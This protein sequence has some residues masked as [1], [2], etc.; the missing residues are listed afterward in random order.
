M[1]TENTKIEIRDA[2]SGDWV[3]AHK[4]ILFSPFISDS[5]YRVYCGLASFAGNKDQRSWPSLITLAS[6]LHM[7]KS[8]VIRAIKLLSTC[9]LVSIEKRSGISNTYTL[10]DC[11]EIELPKAP[12]RAQSTHHQLIDFFHKASIR[13]RNV[14][15][16][17]NG[18]ETAHLK[19]V[20]KEGTLSVE[21]I[22][23]LMVYFLASPRFKKFAPT[24]STFFSAGIFVGLKNAM[25]NDSTFWKDIDRFSSMMFD[26]PKQRAHIPM[27]RMDQLTKMLAEKMSIKKEYEHR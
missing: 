4:N 17:W 19:R 15:P 27:S 8:T 14:K 12:T 1:S 7:G 16:E 26:Q 25:Q 11:K 20:I 23:Q 5:A 22:E 6:R 24:M 21:Q 18:K 10:L 13:F 3:W 9:G 2:R